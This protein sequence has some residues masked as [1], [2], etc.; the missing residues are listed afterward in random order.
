[1]SDELV[2]TT[3]INTDNDRLN[4][5]AEN[6]NNDN[7]QYNTTESDVIQSDS[8]PLHLL[9]QLKPDTQFEEIT[10]EIISERHEFKFAIIVDNQ[11][12]IGSGQSKEIAKTKAAELA[13]EKLFDMCFD[14]Q[15][16]INQYHVLINRSFML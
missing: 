12:F 7:V 13:L 10:D 8:S 16:K 3:T 15:G 4:T 1:L 9:N 6:N 14:K 5:S 2:P 11:R